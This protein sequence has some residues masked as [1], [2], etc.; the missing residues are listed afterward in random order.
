MNSLFSSTAL[1]IRC[2]SRK[3]LSA[4][5]LLT[6]CL[7]AFTVDAKSKI[8]KD[9]TGERVVQAAQV[10]PQQAIIDGDLGG[11]KSP[12]LRTRNVIIPFRK[13]GAIGPLGLRGIQGS[14]SLPFS[15]R[16]DEVV[17]AAKLRINYNYSPSLL[18]ELSHIQVMMNDEV[19]SVIPLPKE[20]NLNNEYEVN[21][22]SR[23]FTDYNKLIIFLLNNA[24][25]SDRLQF[26]PSRP[27]RFML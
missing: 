27:K 25:W 2:K 20:K 17:L 5:L 12:A 21:I 16:S 15:I 1:K 3:I 18:P 11:V 24:L 4:L 7:G 9:S 22:D 23:Y 19:I 6:L 26:R 10:A 13:I 14:V 8:A